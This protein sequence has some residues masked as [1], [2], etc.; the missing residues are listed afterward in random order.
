M[1]KA[2]VTMPIYFKISGFSLGN[3][4]IRLISIILKCVSLTQ[5]EIFRL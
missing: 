3:R 5:V 1:P 2:K 4:D